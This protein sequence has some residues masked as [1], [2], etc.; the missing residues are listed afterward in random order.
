MVLE[1]TQSCLHSPVH[2]SG[3]VR[4]NKFHI[5][6][7]FLKYPYNTGASD[8]CLWKS[9]PSML[10]LSNFKFHCVP[11]L[12][13]HRKYRVMGKFTGR[14]GRVCVSADLFCLSTHLGI[15]AH[16]CLHFP[17]RR[18]PHWQPPVSACDAQDLLAASAAR[19]HNWEETL[20]TTELLK[21][22]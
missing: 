19:K 1:K 5:M 6:K 3:L 14:K 9:S 15:P 16:W 7:Q 11:L 18:Y 8:F 4:R 10:G 12:G 22:Q 20:Q 13:I 2:T 21:P 17:I